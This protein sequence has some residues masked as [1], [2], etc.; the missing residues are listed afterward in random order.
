V[1]N[2]LRVDLLLRWHPAGPWHVGGTT[3][4]GAF[5][6]RSPA[7]GADGRPFVPGSSL[8]GRVRHYAAA[9]YRGRFGVPCP[10][11]TPRSD[12]PSGVEAGP[13]GCGCDLCVLFGAAGFAPGALCF[14]DLGAARSRA[15]VVR[16]GVALDRARRAALGHRFY[17]LEVVEA[18][19]PLEGVIQGWLSGSRAGEQL[20]LVVAALRL[21]PQLGGGRSRGLGW[22]SME[23]VPQGALRDRGPELEE[24]VARWI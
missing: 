19:A 8:K 23:V 13:Q 5:V 10:W 11:Q 20:G 22:G 12:W 7:L 17:S 6:H 16:T 2:K 21:M 3:G 24:W 15:L 1:T 14:G 18:T 9:L 4:G